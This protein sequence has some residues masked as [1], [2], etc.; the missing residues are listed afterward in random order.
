[1]RE[2]SE[3]SSDR[4]IRF[5]QKMTEKYNSSLQEAEEILRQ[6]S[7]DSNPTYLKKLADQYF[8]NKTVVDGN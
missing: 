4:I 8:A 1:M 2:T 5:F 7:D 6:I 3:S